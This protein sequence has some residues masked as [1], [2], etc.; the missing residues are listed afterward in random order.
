MASPSFLYS[1]GIPPKVA[2]SIER[3]MAG[4]EGL[5]GVWGFRNSGNLCKGG[6]EEAFVSTHLSPWEVRQNLTWVSYFTG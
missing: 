5:F 6:A 3:P 1:M 2:S 4:S